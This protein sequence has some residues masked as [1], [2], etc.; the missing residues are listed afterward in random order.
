MN[1][2]SFVPLDATFATLESAILISLW[3]MHSTNRTICLTV[4]PHKV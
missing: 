1:G 4:L 3:L 2:F